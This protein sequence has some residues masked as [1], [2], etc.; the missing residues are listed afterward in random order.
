MDFSAMRFKH[1][2][3]VFSLLTDAFN[4][5]PAAYVFKK[6]LSEG[7]SFGW[8]IG[9]TPGKIPI[10][11]LIILQILS[12]PPFPPVNTFMLMLIHDCIIGSI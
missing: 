10:L 12:Q 9:Y 1:N 8:P 2:F 3:Q 6:R 11:L 7:I 4:F 5:C